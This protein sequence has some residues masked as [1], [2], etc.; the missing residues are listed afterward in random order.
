MVRCDCFMNTVGTKQPRVFVGGR[1]GS[2]S[3]LASFLLLQPPVPAPW[4]V[5]L[6]LWSW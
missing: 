4:K 6:H 1:C 5:L 3:D 2:P